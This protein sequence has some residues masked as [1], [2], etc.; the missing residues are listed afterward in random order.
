[1]RT[2][3]FPENVSLRSSKVGTRTR[4]PAS[5][6]NRAT[7]EVGSTPGFRPTNCSGDTSQSG[8]AT[9]F[10]RMFPFGTS[11]SPSACTSSYTSQ[12]TA[13]TANLSVSA[14]FAGASVVPARWT[15]TGFSRGSTAP[16]IVRNRWRFGS[17][18]FA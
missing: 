12:R 18:D 5:A 15:S 13:K 10:A 1:M 8:I 2:S 9:T 7:C 4:Q 3:G 14:I 17:I 6:S 11:I 16:M